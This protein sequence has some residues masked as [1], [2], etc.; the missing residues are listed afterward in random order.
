MAEY[1]EEMAERMLDGAMPGEFQGPLERGREWDSLNPPE[2]EYVPPKPIDPVNPNMSPMPATPQGPEGY[3]PSAPPQREMVESRTWPVQTPNFIDPST[4]PQIT[5]PPEIDYSLAEKLLYGLQRIGQAGGQKINDM[6]AGVK[7]YIQKNTPAIY[8]NR[9]A[10]QGDQPVRGPEGG[11]MYQRQQVGFQ[12]PFTA[13]PITWD[14]WQETGPPNY[15]WLER[16]LMMDLGM[17]SPI[18]EI[19]EPT[20]MYDPNR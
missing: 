1:D 6:R 5:A 15:N 13:K 14:D 4:F 3:D 12:N 16:A 18:K 2:I 9:Y 10:Y 8:R 11:H 17:R 19:G 20:T 7:N